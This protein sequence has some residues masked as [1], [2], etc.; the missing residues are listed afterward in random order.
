MYKKCECIDA[1]ESCSEEA[2]MKIL[3]KM[4]D[5]ATRLR[6]KY[7]KSAKAKIIISSARSDEI[8]VVNSDTNNKV[9][10]ND[11]IHFKLS[12]DFCLPNKQYKIEGV[13]GRECTVNE[14]KTSSSSHCDNLCCGHGYEEYT[15]AESKPCNCKF[16]WCC[17]VECETCFTNKTKYRCKSKQ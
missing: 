8:L 3:P 9:L 16:V 13:A 7:D 12:L 4:E 14:N 6:K 11:M 17:R 2:C 10:P 15:V 5:I 1:H